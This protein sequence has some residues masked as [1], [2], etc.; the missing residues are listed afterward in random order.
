MLGGHYTKDA[1]EGLPDVVAVVVLVLVGIGVL[2]G[3]LI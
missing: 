3:V 2:I 1:W